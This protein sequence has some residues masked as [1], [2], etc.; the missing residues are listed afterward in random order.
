MLQS[1]R[2]PSRAA[3][4]APFKEEKQVLATAVCALKGLHEQ[5]ALSQKGF[6]LMKLML[7]TI[8]WFVRKSV[9]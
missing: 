3:A 9:R 2:T 1:H 7:G 5:L 6:S 4:V 8:H